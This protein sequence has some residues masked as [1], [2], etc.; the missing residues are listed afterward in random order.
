LF[1]LLVRQEGSVNNVHVLAAFW[2]VFYRVLHSTVEAVFTNEFCFEVAF[3]YL[4]PHECVVQNLVHWR[5][6]QK[7]RPLFLSSLKDYFSKEKYCF[8]VDH[9]HLIVSDNSWYLDYL[10]W[11]KFPLE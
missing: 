5:P 2:V 3:E 10:L 7:F 9:E 8:S 4:L 11:Q 1:G 6:N